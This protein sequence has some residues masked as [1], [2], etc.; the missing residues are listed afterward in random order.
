[1]P[2]DPFL[3][4]Q[5]HP[6]AVHDARPQDMHPDRVE[7]GLGVIGQEHAQRAFELPRAPI[8]KCLLALRIGQNASEVEGVRGFHAVRT[9][10]DG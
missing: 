2:A 4:T 7:V 6:Q 3:S 1:M 10:G 5:A 8:G 9:S